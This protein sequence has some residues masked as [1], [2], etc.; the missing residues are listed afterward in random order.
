L[1]HSYG[2]LS[3]LELT[4]PVQGRIVKRRGRSKQK[5]WRRVYR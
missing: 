4:T 2:T 5:E 1:L 3:L